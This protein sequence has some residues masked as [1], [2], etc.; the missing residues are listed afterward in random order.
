MAH[1]TFRTEFIDYGHYGYKAYRIWFRDTDHGVQQRHE[2][3]TDAGKVEMGD[4]IANP[5]R[6]TSEFNQNL[7]LVN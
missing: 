5:Y 4:W 7:E 6:H 1:Q 2:W 3:L